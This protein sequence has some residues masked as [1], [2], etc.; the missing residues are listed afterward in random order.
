MDR[1]E[2]LVGAKECF[3]EVMAILAAKGVERMVDGDSYASFKQ[4][5]TEEQLPGSASFVRAVLKV[6]FDSMW[7][8]VDE[9]ERAVR[10]ALQP[11]TRTLQHIMGIA[12]LMS[13][14]YRGAVLPSCE[15]AATMALQDRQNLCEGFLAQAHRHLTRGCE[16]YGREGRS[17]YSQFANSA[18]A[19]DIRPSQ[20]IWYEAQ[21]RLWLIERAVADPTREK[22]RL[23]EDL[24]DLVNMC[25][26]LSRAW[27]KTSSTDQSPS[28][29]ASKMEGNG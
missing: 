21:R 12:A 1:Q 18:V 13:T 26:F 27:T 22:P 9:V 7:P 10:I 17:V 25:Y 5:A 28:D 24:I 14:W 16:R 11:S 8:H 29:N 4:A 2:F 19:V 3:D 6:I 23:E 15:S 20:A